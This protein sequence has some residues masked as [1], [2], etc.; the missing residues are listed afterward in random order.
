LTIKAVGIVRDEEVTN[1][2]EFGQG[3]RVRWIWQG[4]TIHEGADE[5]Y[6]V[7]SNTLYEEV[8]PE[9]QSQILEL[10]FSHRTSTIRQDAR[11]GRMLSV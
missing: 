7:R 6:N 2:G 4:S 8:S 11:R 3:V 10:A 1:F 9:I 5:K